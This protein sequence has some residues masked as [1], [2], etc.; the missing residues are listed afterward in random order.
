MGENKAYR[1]IIKT[2]SLFG[3][4]QVFQ[5]LINLIRGKLIAILLGSSGM[6]LNS[7]LVSSMTMMNNI[8]GLGLNFSAVREISKT[9]ETE[10]RSKIIVIF[11]RCLGFTAILGF[12]LTIIFSPAL[13]YFTF[14]RL[15]ETWIF[16]CLAVSLVLN[17]LSTEVVVILQGTRNLSAYAKLTVSISLISLCVNIPVYYFGGIKAIVPA[18]ILSSFVSFVLSK[19]YINRIKTGKPKVSRKETIDKGKEMLKLGIA[20]MAATTIGSTTSYLVNTFIYSYGTASDLGL[21]QAGMSITSQSI[22]LVFSAMSIDYFPRLAAVSHDRIKTRRIVNQQAEI[23]LLLSTP[24]LLVLMVTAPLL[25]HLLLT[26]EFMPLE[27]FIRILAL[28]MFFKAASYPLGTI[29]F[30]KGDKKTFFLLEGAGI[31]IATLIFNILGYSIG[32]LSGLAYSF[33]FVNATY[34]V[35]INIITFKLYS[36]RMSKSLKRIFIIQLLIL[37]LA[38][39]SFSS[40]DSLYAYILPIIL[41]LA[42][43]VFSY[44]Q[45]DRLINL[46]A[47]IISKFSNKNS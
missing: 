8:S 1:S 23:T 22:G 45:L 7:L 29:S 17:I 42:V 32:G 38:F 36:F 13:S 14:S 47:F 28:G 39:L 4:V 16:A 37:A 5:I 2:T 6:G 18:I 30:S 40:L 31:N 33:L 9:K 19:Y 11:R 3:S 12:L 10:S 41:V 20:M 15:D 43:A 24:I 25:I 21:Y 35:A 34:Y 27:G 44:K 46:K 26:S